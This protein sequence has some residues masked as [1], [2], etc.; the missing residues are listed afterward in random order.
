MSAGQVAAVTVWQRQCFYQAPNS[1]IRTFGPSDLVTPLLWQ[2]TVCADHP[3]QPRTVLHPSRRTD[4]SRNRRIPRGC[5]SPR[6]GRETLAH[7]HTAIALSSWSRISQQVGSLNM[8][9][10]LAVFGAAGS[11][12]KPDGLPWTPVRRTRNQESEFAW[13][14]ISMT[15]KPW[16]HLSGQLAQALT[17]R[18]RLPFLWRDAGRNPWRSISPI[19]LSATCC[20]FGAEARNCC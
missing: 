12:A 13:T 3:V 11:F 4:R 18:P 20:F 16:L 9:G 14:Q 17:S 8:D 10:W 15:G 1:A 19:G 5:E 2:S 7:D 6:C